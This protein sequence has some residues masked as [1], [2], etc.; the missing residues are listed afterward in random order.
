MSG[1]VT[2]QKQQWRTRTWDV[3]GRASSGQPSG[4]ARPRA[5]PASAAGR[6]RRHTLA[7]APLASRWAW[8][9]TGAPVLEEDPV[10]LLLS[11]PPQGERSSVHRRSTRA[12]PPPRVPAGPQE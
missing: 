1:T 4:S 11:P 12:P 10:L 8:H 3:S 6:R 5:V 2:I 7:M 9:P